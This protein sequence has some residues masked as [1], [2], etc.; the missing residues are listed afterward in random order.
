MIDG[1]FRADKPGSENAESI[2]RFEKALYVFSRL[3]PN[4]ASHIVGFKTFISIKT[5]IF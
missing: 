2:S 5:E 4:C 3:E 1:H